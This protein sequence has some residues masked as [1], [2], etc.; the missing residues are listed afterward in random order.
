MRNVWAFNRNITKRELY[1]PFLF[2]EIMPISKLVPIETII[3]YTRMGGYT[4]LA[5]RMSGRTL[6]IA[7]A[8]I[9]EAMINPDTPCFISKFE[10][11]ENFKGQTMKRVLFDTVCTMIA[12]LDLKC[13]ELD[14]GRLSVTYKPF[15][16]ERE[17]AEAFVCQKSYS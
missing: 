14:K 17:L 8:I 16:T 2:G 9:G 7:L 12:R 6:G 3:E 15:Y 13:F 10:N 4:H 5:G 11:L 1:A